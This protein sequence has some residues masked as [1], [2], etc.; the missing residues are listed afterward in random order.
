[1]FPAVRDR[2][3]LTEPLYD[4]AGTE[5][6]SGCGATQTWSTVDLTGDGHLDL[7]RG[8]AAGVENFAGAYCRNVS[9]DCLAGLAKTHDYK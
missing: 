9:H 8:I 7:D 2:P 1:M 4:M 5:V 3:A 6:A